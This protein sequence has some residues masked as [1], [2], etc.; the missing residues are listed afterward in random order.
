[1]TAPHSPSSQAPASLAS[2][3]EQNAM[4]LPRSS[5]LGSSW[6]RP[7]P[8]AAATSPGSVHKTPR[9]HKKDSHQDNPD[10][11][12]DP[13]ELAQEPALPQPSAELSTDYKL[14]QATPSMQPGDSA[15]PPAEALKASDAASNTV[16][17][18]P[19][20]EPGQRWSSFLQKPMTEH[21]GSAVAA[22]FG[23]APTGAVL[24]G[25]ALALLAL[26][27]K[28]APATTPQPVPADTQVPILRSAEINNAAG[29]QLLLSFNENLSTA[30]PAAGAFQVLVDGVSTPVSTV[31]RGTNQSTVLL[32]LGTP[33]NG[34][35]SVTVSLSDGSQ[36]K[37]L[38]GNTANTFRD[39]AVSVTDLVLPTL[40][41]SQAITNANTSI[42]VLRFSE[43][44]KSSTVLDAA[45]FKV[46]VAGVVQSITAQEVLGDSVR[47][48]LGSK[49]T[50]AS[51]AINLSYTPPGNASQAVQDTA[52]NLAALIGPGGGIT[53]SHAVDTTAPTLSSGSA[54][55]RQVSVIRLTFSEELDP[56]HLP[57]ATAFLINVAS[58]GTT[59][60][61][62]VNGLKLVGTV[63]ELSLASTVT[64]SS[65]GLQVIYTPPNTGNVLKDWA[66]NPVAS[67]TSN[68]TTV[69]AVAPVLVSSRFTSDRALELTF[70]ED[71]APQLVGAIVDNWSLTANGGA[72]LKPTSF[73]VSGRTLSLGF[74]TAVQSGQAIS[75]AY[76]APTS[77]DTP[78]NRALQDT[79]GNDSASFTRDLDSTGPSLTS[80]TASANGLQVLLNYNEALLVPNSSGTP[81]VPAVA[82][83][84]FVVKRG[85]GSSIT[86]NSVTISGQQVQLNLASAIQ[87]TDTVSVFY[88]PPTANVGVGNAAVQDSSGNDAAALGSG[89][90]GQAVSVTD[91]V[92][93]SLLS[94]KAISNANTSIIVL[95]FSEAL[96]SST[97]LDAANFQVSVAGV[98]QSI[99]A[100]EVLGDSVRLTLGSKIT[101]ASPAIN[102]SYTRPSDT[103]KA[104]QDTAGNLAAPIGSVGGIS[105]THSVDNTA[106]TLSS[107]SANERQVS[108]I[109]LT[110]SEEL[111]PSQ[112][113]VATAFLINV[114]SGGTTRSVAVNGLKLVGTVLELSLASTVTDSSASLQVIYTPPSTGN[115]L[116]DWAGNAV[117]S[118]NSNVTTVDAVAPTFV[119]SRFTSDRTLELTFNEDLAP[120]GAIVD[121]W[122]LTANGGAVLKPTSFTVSGRTL[123]LSF[124]TAVQSGQAISLAYA[125][126]TSDDTPLNRA[127]QD[128]L[129]NDSASFT[130]SLDSTSPILG[131]AT[132]SAN[133][134]Q[135]LLNYNEALLVPG[136][137]G[138]PVA[139]SAFVVQRNGSPI[140]VNNVT[141]SGQQVQLNLA[142]VI[143]PAD[144]VSVFYTPPTA[145]IGVNN[146]AV[147]D[148]SGN[149]AAALGSGVTGQAV[150][151]NAVMAVSQIQLGSKTNLWTR[152]W[153]NSTIPRARAPCLPSA[154]SPSRPARSRKPSPASA[155]TAP[156]APS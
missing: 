7:E 20:G 34:A 65:A 99:T 47:L 24:S 81:V 41:S 75:L 140:T 52:G 137:G 87:P 31:A 26:Q 40:L 18:A 121:N 102:L 73:T 149:D 29:N 11:L 23:I 145:N 138:T 132:T 51:P 76:A 33:V 2:S 5:A 94:S 74:A 37:D 82:A 91:L 48:T 89:V 13:T 72:V 98:V 83:S 66:G 64:D 60:S 27:S 116:K 115:V 101:T 90:T 55:T 156:T 103:S 30:L 61:V 141:I 154:L 133:G 71:L 88:T 111:D 114:T 70:N 43:A 46:S 104:V 152:W 44:L 130:R 16:T 67:L 143:Q 127:L 21:S 131:T 153:C 45:N 119:S 108:V 38:A 56:S 147:Q 105:V 126:P 32:T 92:A 22:W 8:A 19:A 15:E 146:A 28:S 93:P 113:P 12:S 142:S 120:L 58:G 9:P 109:R 135:V 123:S 17:S 107:G 139:A 110:F 69:D 118:L 62:S 124:A 85:N 136:S 78:L 117:A 14:A 148:S 155:A 39:Q 122:S 57:V 97:V 59:R 6:A 3:L 25:G 100:Q 151:N 128:T 35:G 129:G 1:M 77:D 54:I 10:D 63:L 50:T 84:A 49:I 80:A 144:T 42:I 112:L 106:P 68:I 53:V 79:S 4:P 86:V 36:I 150:N 96:K 95:R 125:A 134:L